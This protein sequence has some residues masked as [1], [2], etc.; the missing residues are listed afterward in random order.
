MTKRIAVAVAILAIGAPAALARM[1]VTGWVHGQLYL[2]G[3]PR[4]RLGQTVHRAEGHWRVV[5]RKGAEIVA[6][7]TT[8]QDGTFAFTLRPGSY[9]VAAQYQ[10]P[11]YRFCAV[12]SVTVR[13]NTLVDVRPYCT[14]R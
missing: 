3:G 5:A 9:E 2:S 4:G 8:R 6:T 11:P 10:F 7:T 12:K 14:V 13:P 1:Q